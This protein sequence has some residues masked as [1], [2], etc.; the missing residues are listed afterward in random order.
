MHGFNDCMKELMHLPMIIESA[1]SVM[2]DI[3]FFIHFKIISLSVI[4][5]ISLSFSTLITH[6]ALNNLLQNCNKSYMMTIVTGPSVL[7][8]VI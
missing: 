4:V 3:Y 5:L 8:W 2:C 7:K 6:W 1:I